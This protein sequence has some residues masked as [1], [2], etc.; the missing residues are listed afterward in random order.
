MSSCEE[1]SASEEEVEVEEGQGGGGLR[2]NNGRSPHP[3]DG[4]SP[5]PY[6]DYCPWTGVNAGLPMMGLIQGNRIDPNLPIP[7]AAGAAT[8]VHLLIIQEPV[9][10]ARARR[11]PA[12][13]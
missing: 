2:P 10:A 6:G 4:R 7:G 12:G 8:H 3:L 1:E 13:D 11:G 9:S 5:S